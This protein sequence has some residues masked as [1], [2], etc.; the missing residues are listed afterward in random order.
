MMA[1]LQHGIPVVGTR[2]HH[3]DPQLIAADGKVML[4]TP[5]GDLAAFDAA[6]LRL[7][8]DAQLR[9]QIGTAGLEMFNR[10]Y[11]WPAIAN[12]LIIILQQTRPLAS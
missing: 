11:S 9:A 1:A 7:A 8:S 6:V 12:R 5:S 2:G 10:L 3:T 4:L